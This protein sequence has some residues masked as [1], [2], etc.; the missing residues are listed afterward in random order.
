MITKFVN[1]NEVG[2]VFSIVGTFQALVP[3][4]S[5]PLFGFLYRGTVSYFPAAFLFLV[6]ALKLVEG[7]VVFI[8][9][10]G[11][12]REGNKIINKEKEVETYELGSLMKTDIEKEN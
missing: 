10:I 12:R 9:Y 1:P 3:F 11:L 4:V 8:V 2:K 7:I 5:S 6:A